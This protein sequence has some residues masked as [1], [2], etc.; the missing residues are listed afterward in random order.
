MINNMTAINPAVSEAAELIAA[1]NPA[2]AKAFL[3]RP[4]ARID[5]ACAFSRGLVKSE[6]DDI[7]PHAS[8]VM[9]VAILDRDRRKLQMELA[10]KP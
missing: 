6:T 7:H 1:Y 4:F 3:S 2:L 9:R 10:E 8:L 5:L